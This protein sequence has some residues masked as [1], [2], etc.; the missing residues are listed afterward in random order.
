MDKFI[1]KIFV[2][3]CSDSQRWYCDKVGQIFLAEESIH[4]ERG[5]EVYEDGKLRGFISFEDCIDVSKPETPELNK[6]MAN[7]NKYNEIVSFLN[8]LTNEEGV[9]LPRSIADIL[10]TYFDIDFEQAELERKELEEY[11]KGKI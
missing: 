2:T 11:V 6:L 5:F 4:K 10:H 1:G 9:A 3:K 7:Q 8:Y